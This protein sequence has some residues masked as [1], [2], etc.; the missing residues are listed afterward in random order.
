[1]LRNKEVLNQLVEK[2]LS[3]KSI[4]V[5]LISLF[6]DVS[7]E[8][9]L[10]SEAFCYLEGMINGGIIRDTQRACLIVALTFIALKYYD[11]DFYSY[12]VNNFYKYRHKNL[13]I[14]S[15]V[16][17][18]NA[19]RKALEKER[20]RV[21]YFDSRS[22]VAVPLVLCVVPFYRV[23]DLFK[24]SYD[25]Y[26]QKLLYDED[27]TDDQIDEKVLETLA[28]LRRKDL[29]SNADTIKGT[30][31]LMS[32]YSQSCIYS[33]V[34]IEDLSKI[35]THCI[36]LIISYLSL[37]EDA[38][39]VEPY[40]EE[41]YKLWVDSFN[42]DERERSR[43]E[44]NRTISQPYFRLIKAE[45]YKI[46]LFTGKCTMDD[47]FDPRDVHICIYNGNTLI[48]DKLLTNANDITY[49]NSD[50]AL[51]G[52]I[53][54]RQEI[55]MDNTPLGELYYKVICAG[56]E[57]YN[58]KTK[59]FKSCLF[60]DSKG[61]EVKPGTNYK[62]QL[63][64]VSKESIK[65]EYADVCEL[66]SGK[67]YLISLLEVNN[68][69][70]FVFDGEPFIFYN[71]SAAKL[72]GYEVPWIRFNSFEG[73]IYHV[74]QDATF[75]VPASCEPDDIYVKVDGQQYHLN[76]Y[77]DISFSTR[78]FSKGNDGVRVYSVK[79][80][81]LSA[82]YHN[83]KI[84]NAFSGRR[85]KG[86]D[87]SFIY[88]DKTWKS[89]VK[90]DET[91]ILYNV[92][93]SFFD[94]T[95]LLFEFGVP[96]KEIR[97]FVK[98]LGYGTF[99]L[100]PSSISYSFDA[101]NWFDIKRKM[102]LSEVSKKLKAVYICGPENMTACFYDS[103]AVVKKQYLNLVNDGQHQTIYKLDLS[104]LW[105]IKNKTSARILL[106]FGNRSKFFDVWYNPYIDK[107]KCEFRY[108]SV[109]KKHLFKFIFEGNT[110]IK[111]VIIPF[112]SEAPI[113]E[114]VISSGDIIE[115]ED[116][117]VDSSIKY[118]SI[119]LHGRNFSSIFE[120]Y[121]K[122]PFMIF[123]KKYDLQRPV[124]RLLTYPPKITVNNQRL[125]AF[126]EFTGTEKAIVEVVPSGFDLPLHSEIITSGMNLVLDISLQPFNSY[127]VLLYSVDSKDLTKRSERHFYKSAQIKVHSPFLHQI[128]P[129]SKFILNDGTIMKTYYTLKFKT[130]I[131]IKDEYYLVASLK[132]KN[133]ERC[134]EYLAKLKNVNNLEY[135]FCLFYND[136]NNVR[137]ISLK[138]G[139]TVA[140]AILERRGNF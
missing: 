115:L 116:A 139:K 24:I 31:Y 65:D 107:E 130:I 77:S 59:L 63:F 45:H 71:I 79:I 47:S 112:R 44:N 137:L 60:F 111:A 70:I 50:E 135:E 129:V 122:E 95:Q 89:Y 18:Q 72:F 25:I 12:V 106:E 19:V 6:D 54:E 15:N 55:V 68:K 118:L 120:P 104:Y 17:I 76:D 40:Y 73:K 8:E 67:G 87:I 29:I 39:V 132:Y 105:S 103:T 33:G 9:Y 126:F 10:Y 90:K 117:S 57:I 27:L 53:I 13:K 123:P 3:N 78:L 109:N 42:K 98:N 88:D 86:A 94:E 66:P 20:S 69:D 61:N 26:K 83:V 75:L 43:Y 82:G 52:Y 133:S 131:L 102:Y 14:V 93:S 138:S 32:K 49:S 121:N 56:K 80:Y 114:K 48:L 108:D 91:G 28:T 84:F 35:M 110:K 96:I 119:A 127:I 58:S 46:H 22:H 113:L 97:G 125:S 2:V 101:V 85:I 100:F 41:G 128:F 140:V 7:F 11:G 62:G 16:S 124:P 64:V 136:C 1:M 92:Q 37:P 21:K 4:A 5:D 30:N 74:F 99:V 134:I 34:G 36:R 51:N 81:G 38:F 23:K